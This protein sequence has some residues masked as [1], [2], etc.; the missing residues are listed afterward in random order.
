M[1]RYDHYL[2]FM[3]NYINCGGFPK[4]HV[5]PMQGDKQSQ[6]LPAGAS[7]LYMEYPPIYGS[8]H[9]LCMDYGPLTKWDAHPSGPSISLRCGEAS[10]TR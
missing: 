6:D 4:Q 9:G 3:I 7:H 10:A 2:E 1:I 5:R 8:I